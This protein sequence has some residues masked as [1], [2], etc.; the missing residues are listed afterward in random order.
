MFALKSCC[1]DSVAHLLK[2]SPPSPYSQHPISLSQIIP[3]ER[4]GA[5]V[6]AVEHEPDSSKCDIT[7]FPHFLK[8]NPV[9]PQRE[10]FK[11]ILLHLYLNFFSKAQVVCVL[12]MLKNKGLTT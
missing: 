1:E 6:R 5:S 11:V 3:T 7:Y 10:I 9:G 4:K 2:L 8:R 12:L